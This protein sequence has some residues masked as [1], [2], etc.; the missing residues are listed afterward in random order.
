MAR[1][2]VI[3]DEEEIR[4]IVRKVLTRNDHEIAEA[5]NGS[6]ALAM[7]QQDQCFDLVISDIFMPDTDGIETLRQ[8]RT[9]HPDLK[10][11]V[12]SG[13]G[14]RVARDYL[15]MAMALGASLTVAKPFDPIELA[16]QV[17]NLLA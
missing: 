4:S 15:P 6:I 7:L 12:I 2:L 5:E 17:E 8:I 13:G 1:I 10:V 14:N 11:V 3:D 9:M 16:E